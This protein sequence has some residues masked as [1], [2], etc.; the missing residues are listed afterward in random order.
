SN[1]NPEHGK[2]IFALFFADRFS[3]LLD[4]GIF[5]V[6]SSVFAPAMIV[7]SDGM[8]RNFP[9]EPRRTEDLPR[10]LYQPTWVPKHAMTGLSLGHSPGSD[11]GGCIGP[12]LGER[13]GVG[14]EEL[15]LASV[16]RPAA[17]TPSYQRLRR[18]S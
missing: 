13:A 8:S 15:L 12:R 16:Q 14:K 3:V 2:S 17:G 4:P 18:Q 1:N 5:K 9:R 11:A 10:E 7:A 6:V